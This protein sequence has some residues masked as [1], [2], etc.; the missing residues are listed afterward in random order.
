LRRIVLLGTALADQS[1][2]GT[3]IWTNKEKSHAFQPC[4]NT[5]YYYYEW[6][7]L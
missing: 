2:L 7:P 4:T 3:T 6:S 5:S 1:L